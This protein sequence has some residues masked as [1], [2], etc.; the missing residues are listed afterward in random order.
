MR[1]VR[2]CARRYVE[3]N[4]CGILLQ[5]PTSKLAKGSYFHGSV[6]PPPPRARLR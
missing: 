6:H 3:Q 4:I 2:V 5:Q 1:E